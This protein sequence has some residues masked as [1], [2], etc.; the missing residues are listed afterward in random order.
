MSLVCAC[1]R[2][3]GVYCCLENLSVLL[4]RPLFWSI[5]SAQASYGSTYICMFGSYTAFYLPVNPLDTFCTTVCSSVLFLSL[6][7][8]FISECGFLE[9]WYC[10]NSIHDFVLVMP[11]IPR[12]LQLSVCE[13]LQQQLCWFDWRSLPTHQIALSSVVGSLHCVSYIV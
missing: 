11:F 6:D 13:L 3:M 1:Q 7:S 12:S 10:G 4:S 2:S 9:G 8:C 5:A